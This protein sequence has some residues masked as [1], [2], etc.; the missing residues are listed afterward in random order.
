MVY[1]NNRPFV[2]RDSDHP[3]RNIQTFKGITW[4]HLREVEQR[5][6]RDILIEASQ[7]HN[8][9]IHKEDVNKVEYIYS[10]NI[11]LYTDLWIASFI[12]CC[13]NRLTLLL[14]L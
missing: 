1:L 5:L 2:L 8:I 12:F 6:K 11:T 9:L 13:G 7:H 4:Q 14:V 3:F 10:C